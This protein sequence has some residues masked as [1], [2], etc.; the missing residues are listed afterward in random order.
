MIDRA[1]WP[2][3][4]AELEMVLERAA[5][6]ITVQGPDGELVYAN[7]SAAEAM[8]FASAAELLMTPASDLLDRF[9]I[10]D[11]SGNELPWSDL[12][13]RRALAG[14]SGPPRIVRFRRRD[15]GE[16]HWS[17]VQATAVTSAASGTRFVV[18]TFQDVTE[19]KRSEQQLRILADVGSVLAQSNGSGDAL[20]RLA[21]LV[22]TELADWCVVDVL[23]GSGPRRLAVAHADP[24]KRRLAEEIERRYPPD[25]ERASSLASV[26]RTGRAI[27]TTEVSRETLRAAAA[28]EEHFRLLEQAGIGSAV[29]LPLI[30]RGQVLGA[31]TLVRAPTREPYSDADLPLL[32]ELARR[33]ALSVD[34]ARLL[35]EANEAVRLRDDFLAMAS[36]DM[37]TPLS[38]ILANIQLARRKLAAGEHAD[39]SRHMESAE[40]TTQKMTGLVGELMDVTILRAGHQLPLRHEHADLAAIARAHAED[41][42]RMSDQHRVVV[43]APDTLVGEWDASRVE[44]VLRNLLDNALKYSPHGGDIRLDVTEETDASGRRWAAIA[45]EDEGVGIPEDE[46]PQ[47]FEK[48][49]RGSNTRELRGTGLGLAGSRAVIEQLGGSIEVSSRLGVGSVFTVRLPANAAS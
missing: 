22:I 10:L 23:D 24:A 49:H 26:V 6:A 18:N 45:V 17:L 12:P 32:E 8:G 5:D 16:E 3:T 11:E 37:R 46:L 31:M 41:Y 30:A 44:R 19:L 13:S 47:L 9:A 4:A 38:V 34:N 48:Y 39:A 20:R 7:H 35:E 40:R 43:S 2:G 33:A 25:A 1:G 42:Q 15:N 29:V 28:D 21:E 27:V 14:E 36:H